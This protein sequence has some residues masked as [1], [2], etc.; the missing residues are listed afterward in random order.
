MKERINVLHV[1]NSAQGGSALS[2]FQL[3]EEL[4]KHDVQSSLVCFNNASEEQKSKILELVDNRVIFIPLYWSNKRTRVTRWKRPLLEA[5]TAWQTWWGYKYQSQ[6]SKLIH[7]NQINIVHTST[8]V[9]PEGAIAAR[10]NKLP[11]VWHVRELIGPGTYYQFPNFKK[12]TAMVS[13]HANVL[14]ANSTI[15]KKNLMQFFPESKIQYVPNGIDID[16]YTVKAHRTSENPLLVGMVAN[17]TSRLKNHEFFIRTALRFAADPA[18]EFRIYGALPGEQ[19]AYLQHLKKIIAENQ[20]ETKVKFVGHIADPAKIMEEIDILFH[21]T[22]LESF[23][24][25]FTEAMAGGIPVIAVEQGGAL[26]LIQQGVNG[27][28][29]KENDDEG[30]ALQIRKFKDPDRRN[31]FGKNGRTIAE[32][33]YTLERTAGK[34]VEVYQTML[35]DRSAQTNF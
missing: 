14:I 23:G 11:H 10:R 13:S 17:V 2:T 16:T 19:D 25:I 8:I 24:R 27:F 12:W 29:V 7:N 34:M 33:Y 22:G 35:M 31:A 26:E 32:H 9:N 3:I 20:A 28:L 18:F 1:L 5:L 6:I 15:T 30:A 4:K 21:P